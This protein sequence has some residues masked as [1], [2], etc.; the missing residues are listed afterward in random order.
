[1]S[2][3]KQFTREGYHFIMKP[4]R[5]NN[6]LLLVFGLFLLYAAFFL[7]RDNKGGFWSATVIGGLFVLIA[8]AT[9][10]SKFV[11]DT[12]SRQIMLK[13]GIPAQK[14]F[15]FDA[16]E[17]FTVHTTT[18]IGVPINRQ[19]LI[20]IRQPGKADARP[21]IVTQALFSARGLQQIADE[22]SQIVDHVVA[23]HS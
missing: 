23:D 1:M 17:G 22:T 11:L 21:Y 4:N 10:K 3:F 5:S 6:Y 9:W 15:A 18:Y 14:T 16:F 2:D 7:L 13:S 12:A 8:V 19:L 20:N